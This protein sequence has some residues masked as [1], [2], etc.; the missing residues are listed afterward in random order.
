MG[1]LFVS[2]IFGLKSS[3]R[4]SGSPVC[5]LV[6][7]KQFCVSIKPGTVGLRWLPCSMVCQFPVFHALSW[8]QLVLYSQWNY[9]HTSTSRRHFV[10]Q[11][12]INDEFCQVGVEHNCMDCSRPF[13]TRKAV[14]NHMVMRPHHEIRFEGEYDAFFD[15]AMIRELQVLY[16]LTSLKLIQ[17]TLK[18]VMNQASFGI[19]H[20]GSD[21][22]RGNVG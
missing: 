1:H 8:S 21:F 6:S 14:R 20:L 7:W 9:W 3:A 10:T 13:T 18:L 17:L 19:K 5:P 11:H 4:S 15:I 2:Y 12:N 22:M 16:W